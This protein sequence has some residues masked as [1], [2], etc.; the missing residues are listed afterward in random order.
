MY[1]LGVIAF[2]GSVSHARRVQST[3][4]EQSRLLPEQMQALMTDLSFQEQTKHL[5]KPL[6]AH[7][8]LAS[9]LLSGSLSLVGRRARRS[10]RRVLM[11]E[12][13]KIKGACKWFN[14]EKGFGFIERDDGEADVFVHQSVIHA[15][16]FRSL[17]EGEEVEFIL[18]EGSN[19]KMAAADVTGPDG[20]FVQGAPRLMDNS[21]DDGEVSEDGW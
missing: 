10:Q 17:A 5:A 4:D 19:G 3:S 2:L 14:A 9:V 12:G 6:S 7:K 20:E 8:S 21:W 1:T 11:D 15:P 13:E 16:G 18:K